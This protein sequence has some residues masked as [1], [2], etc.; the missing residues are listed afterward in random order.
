MLDWSSGFPGA[1]LVLVAFAFAWGAILG[2][3]VNVVIHR[4]PRGESVV[5]HGSRCPACGAAI[6]PRDNVPVVGWLLLGGRC[7]DCGAA[8]SAGYPA[9]EAACGVLAA[10]IAVAELAGTGSPLLAGT[11]PGIDRLLAGDGRIALAWAIHTIVPVAMLAWSLTP[12]GGGGT[13]PARTGDRDASDCQGAALLVAAVIVAVTAVPTVGPPMVTLTGH[14]PA[15][16]E[17]SR[18]AFVASCFGAAA[19]RLAG[20]VTGLPGDRCGLAAC[21][22]AAGW[23]FVAIVTVV[24][25]LVRMLAAVTLP[26]GRV[27]RA[28]AAAIPAAVA[29]G[30]FAAWSPANAAWAACWRMMLSG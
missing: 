22:A 20:V 1:E 29:G 11:R 24:T 9:V 21:G 25:V 5:A 10:V 13:G 28:V 12:C 7:R 6:R 16:M 19:G 18:E 2:S 26:G 23:Q 30:A 8:I 27:G 15:G 17:G 14:D 4:L 3:F